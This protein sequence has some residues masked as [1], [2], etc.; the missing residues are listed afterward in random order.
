MRNKLISTMTLAMAV[1]GC[2]PVG[3]AISDQEYSITKMGMQEVSN[4]NESSYSKT[5]S[6]EATQKY[7]IKN[8]SG[9]D[10]PHWLVMKVTRLSGDTVLSDTRD[11]VVLIEDG[12][13][14]EE[15]SNYFSIS[16]REEGSLEPI[17]CAFELI[18]VQTFDAKAKLHRGEPLEKT[19]APE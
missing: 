14:T 4:R 12:E 9:F 8:E 11:T 19:Q 1:A 5:V 17:T 16:S 3:T 2:N 7:K 15:C 13:A 18:G 6:F 10:E